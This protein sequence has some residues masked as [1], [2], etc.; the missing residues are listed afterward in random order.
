M[1]LSYSQSARIINKARESINEERQWEQY[2]TFYPHM[3]ITQ[4]LNKEPSLKFITYQEFKDRHK[5]PTISQR[6]K[7]EILSEVNKIREE[8]TRQAINNP[9][10]HILE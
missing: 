9:P 10:L 3:V 1:E 4:P 8:F 6:P 5:K 2:L 7:E